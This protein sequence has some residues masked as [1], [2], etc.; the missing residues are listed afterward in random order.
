[1]YETILKR[2]ITE[3]TKLVE[4]RKHN[5]AYV[6]SELRR[7]REGDELLKGIVRYYLMHCR[8]D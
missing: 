7:T 3:L 1:M 4:F 8:E 6:V 2:A 5:P